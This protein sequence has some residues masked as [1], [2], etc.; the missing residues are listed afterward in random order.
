LTAGNV[1]DNSILP[2]PAHK[3]PDSLQHVTL[4]N[5]V[6]SGIQPTTLSTQS[7]HILQT[8]LLTNHISKTQI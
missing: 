4:H 8:I 5:H 3:L 7:F 2:H 1:G 6:S